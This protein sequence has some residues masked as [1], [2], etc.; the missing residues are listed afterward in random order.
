MSERLFRM[1]VGGRHTGTPEE[2]KE[3]LLIGACKIGPEGFG[4]FE[5]GI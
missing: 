2:G 4:G 3:K 5:P 1:V